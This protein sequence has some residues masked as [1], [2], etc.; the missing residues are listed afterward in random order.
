VGR[1]GLEL[2]DRRKPDMTAYG[3]ARPLV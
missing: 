1:S 2:A 3:D